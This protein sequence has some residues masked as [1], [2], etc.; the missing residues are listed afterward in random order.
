MTVDLASAV[1]AFLQEQVRAGVGSDPNELA[2]DLLRAIRSQQRLP[3]AVTPELE[4]WLLTSAD[5]PV[6]PLKSEDFD[7]IRRRG[8]A[9]TAF[10]SP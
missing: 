8:R 5:K 6:S 4:A 7:A 9:R 2:N 3:F 10:G 1:E